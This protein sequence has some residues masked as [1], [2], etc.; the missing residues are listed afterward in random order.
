MC[1]RCSGSRR[2]RC[3]EYS[4]FK[5]GKY[6]EI[7]ENG[8]RRRKNK[9]GAEIFRDMERH[10]ERSANVNVVLDHWLKKRGN[11][12]EKGEKGRKKKGEHLEQA[13]KYRNHQRMREQRKMGRKERGKRKKRNRN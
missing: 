4:G 8:R 2:R 5:G 12:G 9:S 13:K 11:L 10:R 3:R 6:S 1:S 7:K